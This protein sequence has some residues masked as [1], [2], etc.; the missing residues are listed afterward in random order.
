[1]VEVSLSV[2]NTDGAVLIKIK[3]HLSS[4]S[5]V[6]HVWIRIIFTFPFLQMCL[7]CATKVN[8]TKDGHAR[9]L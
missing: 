6:R 2:C 1:V 9:T 8:Y 3:M 7:N 5:V 4:F